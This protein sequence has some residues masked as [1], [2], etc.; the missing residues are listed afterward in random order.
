MKNATVIFD[1]SN[2]F[3]EK[4]CQNISDFLVLRS[5]E[6]HNESR[7]EHGEPPLTDEQIVRLYG[8]DPRKPREGQPQPV[9]L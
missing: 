4:K 3:D 6:N 1:L 5:L 2:G 8:Y 7:A 9:K